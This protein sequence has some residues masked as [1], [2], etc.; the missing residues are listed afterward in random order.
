MLGALAALLLA[1]APA[2]PPSSSACALTH[3]G[4]CSD[5]NRLVWAPGFRA[6]VTRFFDGAQGD[7]LYP[8][9]DMA[10]Q[11]MEAL[12]GPPDPSK[13]L[14]TG[15]WLFTACR[16]H[17]CPEKGAAVLTPQGRILAIGLLNFRCHKAAAGGTDCDK[18]SHLDI[19]VRPGELDAARL[20][21]PLDAWAREK[22]VADRAQFGA[23]NMAPYAGPKIHEVTPAPRR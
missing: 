11:A 18:A 3:L 21:E 7:H 4:D 6:A 14:A 8:G 9:G 19:Y 23:A 5:T 22:A 12:G 20:I 17:S 10:D 16:A 2:P 1:A 15:S 13:R